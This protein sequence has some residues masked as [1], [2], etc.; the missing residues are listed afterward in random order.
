MADRRPQT[1]AIICISTRKASLASRPTMSRMFGGYFRQETSLGIR[2]TE[3][4]LTCHCK[5][6]PRGVRIRPCEG[7][8]DDANR[9]AEGPI[10]GVLREREADAI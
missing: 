2:A 6:P 3:T 10:I 1:A 8:K 4:P 5:L 7:R 9:V